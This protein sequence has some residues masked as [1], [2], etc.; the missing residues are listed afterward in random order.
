MVIAP[1]QDG[2]FLVKLLFFALEDNPNAVVHNLL[3]LYP[4]HYTGIMIKL[5][6]QLPNLIVII[7]ISATW[8]FFCQTWIFLLFSLFA[9]LGLY[10]FRLFRFYLKNV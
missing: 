7:V 5:Y 4:L 10:L 1:I 8:P 3:F 2:M 9:M 6:N